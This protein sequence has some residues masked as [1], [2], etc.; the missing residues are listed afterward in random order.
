MKKTLLMVAYA[1]IHATAADASPGVKIVCVNGVHPPYGAVIAE[2]AVLELTY[3]GGFGSG[4]NGYEGTLAIQYGGTDSSQELIG[5]KTD[6]HWHDISFYG[7][8]EARHSLHTYSDLIEK[9][10]TRRVATLKQESRAG[11]SREFRLICERVI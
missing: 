11:W 10:G 5:V 4:L 6:T 8:N 9:V 7:E 2:K 1:F 3:K